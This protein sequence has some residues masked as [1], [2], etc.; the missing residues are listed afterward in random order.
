MFIKST[1][2]LIVM[3]LTMISPSFGEQ[4]RIALNKE[5]ILNNFPLCSVRSSV[6]QKCKS[7]TE[8]QRAAFSI[9][10]LAEKSKPY[11]NDESIIIIE[12]ETW[13]YSFSLDLS[14]K[15][16]PVISFTD[17]ANLG[18]YYTSVSYN[19]MYSEEQQNLFFRYPEK[20]IQISEKRFLKFPEKFEL[21]IQKNN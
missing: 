14:D 16:N 4:K 2:T 9:K 10:D 12:D 5:Y 18:T 3:I 6:G 19:L 1:I 7:L 20:V 17:D 21:N 8:S 15:H 11:S 13:Y